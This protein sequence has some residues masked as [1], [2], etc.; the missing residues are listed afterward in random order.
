MLP[1]NQIN[2]P[3]TTLPLLKPEIILHNNPAKDRLDRIRGKEPA[4][5]SLAPESKVHV[6]R[7]DTHETGR[8][9]RGQRSRM[10]LLVAWILVWFRE[11]IPVFR[12]LAPA[13]S[14]EGVWVR[15]EGGVFAYRS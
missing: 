7:T 10:R 8:C 4:R 15:D 9:G 13:K 3:P 6:R 1:N 5:A 2:R 14:I 11:C 12:V